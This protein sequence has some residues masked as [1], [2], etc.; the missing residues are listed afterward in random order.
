MQLSSCQPP[1][2]Q[3]QPPVQPQDNHAK[4]LLLSIKLIWAEVRH[5][6]NRDYD[7]DDDDEMI[8]IITII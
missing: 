5:L 7:D 4:A 6:M 1:P 8:N 3:H 2:T